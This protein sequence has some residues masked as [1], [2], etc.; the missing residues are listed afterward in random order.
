MGDEE[1][2]PIGSNR[3]GAAIADSIVLR[4]GTLT[5]WEV[6]LLGGVEVVEPFFLF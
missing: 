3:F 1:P 5:N 4:F 6:N 2:D